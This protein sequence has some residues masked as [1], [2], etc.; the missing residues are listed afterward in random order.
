MATALSSSSASLNVSLSRPAQGAIVVHVAGEVDAATAPD[1]AAALGPIWS[2]RPARVVLDLSGVSFLGTAGLSELLFAAERAELEQ[3]T[4]R[5]VGPHCVRR[6]LRAAGLTDRL[7][8]SADL[9][10]AL[11]R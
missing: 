7:P 1:L 8:L 10:E 6:A 5:L 4:L 2:S 11:E 3:V 9:G